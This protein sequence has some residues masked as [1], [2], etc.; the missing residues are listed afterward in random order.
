MAGLVLAGF[1]A[2]VAGL[3]ASQRAG[4]HPATDAATFAM[5]DFGRLQLWG[6]EVIFH[7][8]RIQRHAATG[9]CRLIDGQNVRHAFGSFEECRAALEQIKRQRGLPTMTGKVVLLLHGLAHSRACMT[10]LARF[11]EHNSD[12]VVLNVEYPGTH[13]SIAASARALASIVDHLGQVEEV[14]FVAHSM[15][16]LIVRRYLSDQMAAKPGELGPRPG[17]KLAEPGRPPKPRLKRMVMLAPPNHGSPIAD[18][19]ADNTLFRLLL[20]KPGQELGRHWPWQEVDLATP[21]FE[22]GGI[23]GGLGDAV[24]YNPL[25]PGDDDGVVSVQSTRLAGASDFLVLPLTHLAILASPR[26][27][28]HT[29]SFLKRG[30]FV[31]PERRQPIPKTPTQPASAANSADALGKFSEQ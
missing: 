17:E 3:C 13:Q 20:G 26:V 23:A 10:P 14:S 30:F 29:L 15:G 22:F 25:L 21:P 27:H 4:E 7:Q 8:W 5:L 11:L 12:Y 18:A 1:L 19:L 24:G 28:K 31:S 6:D 9:R 2:P 16:C